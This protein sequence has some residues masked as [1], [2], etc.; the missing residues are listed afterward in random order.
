MQ[1]KHTG[2]RRG[3]QQNRSQHLHVEPLP[4][5][6]S[7]LLQ[8]RRP[9]WRHVLASFREQIRVL[10]H[11]GACCC[12]PGT[13]AGH[14]T[15][16]QQAKAAAELRKQQLRLEEGCASACRVL[17]KCGR[18][19]RPDLLPL[20]LHGCLPC[21]CTAC[22]VLGRRQRQHLRLH[23][24]DGVEQVAVLRVPRVGGQRQGQALVRVQLGLRARAG[25]G[26]GWCCRQR[27]SCS[28]QRR[29]AEQASKVHQGR[30]SP[31][32]APSGSR[33]CSTRA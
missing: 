33:L 22:T 21:S 18:G 15:A 31:S 32:A 24:A 12:L 9:R 16:V 5:R 20:L 8:L 25:T 2:R 19:R 29:R 11:C 26:R 7:V 6:G 23:L 1:G 30:S 4:V 28:R 13:A 10:L 27:S 14:C 17:H 3:Q